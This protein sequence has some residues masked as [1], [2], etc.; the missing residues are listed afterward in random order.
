MRGPSQAHLQLPTDHHPHR[1]CAS[2]TTLSTNTPWDSSDTG[3]RRRASRW[4][5]TCAYTR[6]H[7]HTLAHTHTHTGTHTQTHTHIHTPSC[8]RHPPPQDNA[9]V[10]LTYNYGKETYTKGNAY[11]Q[12]RFST[13]LLVCPL[14]AADSRAPPRR[15]CRGP[16]QGCAR[17]F[18][19]AG[20]DQHG[21]CVQ[22]SGADQVGRRHGAHRTWG[23][24][25]RGR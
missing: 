21:R 15:I 3:R 5:P 14:A 16:L 13:P 24:A 17:A 8:P 7:S 23:G 2:E 12:A 19:P 4:A 11:T 22:N 6:T 1:S 25:R 20:G 18:P 9:V 10:E